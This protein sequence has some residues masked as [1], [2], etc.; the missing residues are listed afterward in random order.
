MDASSLCPLEE[1][2]GLCEEG[3]RPAGT[4]HFILS[5]WRVRQGGTKPW[6]FQH[7]LCLVSTQRPQPRGA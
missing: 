7:I 2:E 6:I 1:T 4:S 3:G 5:S